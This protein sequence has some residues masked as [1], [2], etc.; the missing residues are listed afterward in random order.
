MQALARAVKR[1]DTLFGTPTFTKVFTA[2]ATFQL[3]LLFIK[4]G[5][6]LGFDQFL[7]E[8]SATTGRL[9]SAS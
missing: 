5:A 8:M 1:I 4:Y 3:L 9:L 7:S 6:S 2:V